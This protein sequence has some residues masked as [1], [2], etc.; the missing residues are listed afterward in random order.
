MAFRDL[1]MADFLRTH[2]VGATSLLA[3]ML[4]VLSLKRQRHI[5][6]LLDG[7]SDIR[8]HFQA[9]LHK[10]NSKYIPA[11]GVFQFGYQVPGS[12]TGLPFWQE[13]ALICR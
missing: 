9:S 1:F 6:A 7:K 12:L 10:S 4:N 5:G 3:T 11:S 13:F 8:D 2:L